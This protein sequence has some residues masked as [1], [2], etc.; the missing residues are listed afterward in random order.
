MEIDW[1]DVSTQLG[2]GWSVAQYLLGAPRS[3]NLV[4]LARSHDP[5]QQLKD[6]YPG[7]VEVLSGD[8]ANL[9]LGQEA[10]SL[11]LKTFG[12]LDGMVINH[13][14]LGPVAR[15]ENSDLE[16][17]KRGFDINFFSAAALVSLKMIHSRHTHLRQ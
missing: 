14:I 10:V 7:Q 16:A 2:I 12:R 15:L 8:L 1:A 9:G 4:V 5:L 17:W 6:Q 3:N 11:A 13:G